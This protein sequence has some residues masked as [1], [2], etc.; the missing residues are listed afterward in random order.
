MRIFVTGAN[1]FVGRHLVR[2]LLESGHEVTAG[3]RLLGS[4]PSGSSEVVVGDIGSGTDWSGILEGQDVV[5]H[6]A[7]RVHVMNDTSTD[8]LSEFREVNSFGTEKLA[9]AAVS[10]SVARLVFLSSLK[11]NGEATYGTPYTAFDTPRPID[12]Y[13][14][15]KHEAEI[16]LRRVERETGIDVVIVRTPLV[17]GPEVGGNFANL[18]KVAAKGIPLPLG[19]VSN[20]RTMTSVWNLAHLLEK[21]ATE[22]NASG[23]LIRAGDAFTSSTTQLI[24]ELAA[25]TNKPSRNFPFPVAILELVG[26]IFGKAEGVER[27]TGSLEVQSGSTTNAAWNWTPPFEVSRRNSCDREVVSRG[28]SYRTMRRVIIGVTIDDSLQ[29]HSD[30]PQLLV[31]DGW[32]VHVVAGPGRRIEALRG[33]PGITVHVVRM[34][35]KPSPIRDVSSFL[36]WVRIIHSVKPDVTLIGTPKAALLGNVAARLLKVRRRIYI[37]HG[38]RL[39]TSSGLLRRVLRLMERITTTSAHEVVVVSAS[40]KQLAI[41]LRITP[42]RKAILLG[43]G[44]SNGGDVA[45]FRALEKHP[46]DAG[47]AESVGID[48]S[49]PTIGFVG[50]LTRDK[51]LPERADVLALLNAQGR[52]LQLLVVGGVDDDSGQAALGRLEQTG[53]P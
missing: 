45:H 24:E 34:A 16:A 18:L 9:R 1:G 3:V 42:E 13:G 28:W 29:F 31:A 20:R 25:A 14:V 53:S 51:G 46:D 48:P 21:S 43:S 5:I 2:H 23:G 6:L 52:R 26:R 4:A 47:L 8:P 7:A 27:L 35:R 33:K 41:D 40:L 30:L 15:S 32:D 50:R 38:L 49:L 39:E 22:T 36:D 19:S 17:Y 12:P 10:Q 37:L 11:V 44:R